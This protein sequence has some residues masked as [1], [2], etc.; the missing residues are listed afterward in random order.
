MT[1]TTD[2][3]R[4]ALHT[5]AEEVPHPDPARLLAGAHRKREQGKRVRTAVIAGVAAAV[6]AIVTVIGIQGIG[7]DKALTPA[8]LNKKHHTHY[9]E[10][11]HGLKL[12]DI[13][14]VPVRKVADPNDA[15]PATNAVSTTLPNVGSTVY[16]ACDASPTSDRDGYS[17][18]QLRSS[19]SIFTPCD[20]TTSR[21]ALMGS[22]KPGEHSKLWIVMD[23]T[24]KASKAPIAIYTQMSW[25]D[26]PVTTT[27][28]KP[29]PDKLN[30]RNNP[31]DAPKFY[32][33]LISGSGNAASS[34]TVHVPASHLRGAVLAMQPSS[35]GRFQVLV[36]GKS[37]RL[38]YT[39]LPK[40]YG[41]PFGSTAAYL[42]GYFSPEMRGKWLDYWPDSGH[43]NGGQPPR[44][45]GPKPGRSATITIR[46]IDTEG[47]WTAMLSWQ[48]K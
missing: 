37:Q 28:L 46:A 22:G 32:N 43:E 8:Q 25:D 14:D 4:I 13:V 40:K 3:L 42:G 19:G 36:D 18:V 17:N 39:G 11:T 48:E 2:E 16:V 12:T 10:Y 7:H 44:F 15:P 29:K 47:P 20:P 21:S 31:T 26:Y 30:P 33:V 6:M 34:K 38:D 27:N 41:G 5:Y 35:T 45:E 1:F 24:P 23:R 9:A